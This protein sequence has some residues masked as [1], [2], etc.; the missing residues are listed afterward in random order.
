MYQMS[1]DIKCINNKTIISKNNKFMS[2]SNCID[3]NRIKNACIKGYSIDIN[4][5]VS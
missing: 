5:N 4:S 1:K 3:C 2:I